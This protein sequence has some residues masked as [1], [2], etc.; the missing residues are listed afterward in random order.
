MPMAREVA[1]RVFAREL[2]ASSLAYKESDDQFA[3]SYVLTPT[4][5]KCNRVFIVGTLTEKE[6]VG[7]DQESWRARVTDPT[8]AFVVY[9]SQF[10]PDAAQALS[11]I[12]APSFVAVVGKPRVFR[13][14][15]GEFLVSVRPESVLPVDA[16]TRD[17]WVLDAID[18]TADRLVALKAGIDPDARKAEE[19]YHPA[20]GE[21]KEML[22]NA[23][24]SLKQMEVSVVS[25][26]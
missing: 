17:R 2:N 18:A 10:S 26:R 24:K 3:P 25:A 11:D 14:Q 13:T 19:H 12:E 16:G 8:G 23:A 21:Y 22:A 4:G 5:A 1:R 20:I 6:N 9:A 15:D 7:D